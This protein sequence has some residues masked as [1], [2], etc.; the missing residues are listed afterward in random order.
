MAAL[1]PAGDRI[2]QHLREAV[3]RLQDDVAR[4]ELWA[5]ALG[6]FAKPVPDYDPAQSQLNKF[7]LPAK[8][9]QP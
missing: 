8:P 6:C 1:E 4:V 5:G 2:V 9:K 3:E 7:M